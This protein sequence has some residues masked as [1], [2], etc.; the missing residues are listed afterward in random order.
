MFNVFR[1]SAAATPD[2]FGRPVRGMFAIGFGVFRVS[3]DP[4]DLFICIADVAIS[5]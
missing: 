3:I 5:N 2:Y 1:S 4:A